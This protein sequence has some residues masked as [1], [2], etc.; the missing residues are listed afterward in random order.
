[1]KE[2]RDSGNRTRK[3]NKT[4]YFLLN[5]GDV[6]S[7]ILLLFDFIIETDSIENFCIPDKKRLQIICDYYGVSLN[8]KEE[9]FLIDNLEALKELREL[10]VIDSGTLHEAREE[11]IEKI[12]K[13]FLE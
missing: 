9:Y 13:W 10:C 7:K 3:P 11:F 2:I 6:F 5:S 12:Q 1:M 8:E 4:I